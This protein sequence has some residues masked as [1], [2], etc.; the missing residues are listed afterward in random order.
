MLPLDARQAPP[1][2]PTTLCTQH[3]SMEMIYSDSGCKHAGSDRTD[4]FKRQQ[5]ARL[6][7]RN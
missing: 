4:Q 6:Q 5:I 2:P 3:R 7:L 1:P